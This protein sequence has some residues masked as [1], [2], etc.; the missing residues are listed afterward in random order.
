MLRRQG[1][2]RRQIKEI[3]G[4]MSATLNGA[5]H[6]VNAHLRSRARIRTSVQCSKGTCLAD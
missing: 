2:S 4:P 6:A 3:L 1:E 5:S